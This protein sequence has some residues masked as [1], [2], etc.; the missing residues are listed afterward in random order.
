[1]VE[2]PPGNVGF[3]FVG[4]A[5]VAHVHLAV[6][7]SHTKRLEYVIAVKVL[8][9]VGGDFRHDWIASGVQ[10]RSRQMGGKSAGCRVAV[11]AQ[12][13]RYDSARQRCHNTAK[14]AFEESPA[15]CGMEQAFP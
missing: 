7:Q 15:G 10:V 9:D 12:P 2:K 5:D 11:P 6:V 14:S 13:V 4:S 8:Q 3:A 1:M